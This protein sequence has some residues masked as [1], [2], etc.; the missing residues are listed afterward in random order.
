MVFQLSVVIEF[1][2]GQAQ[3]LVDDILGLFEKVWRQGDLP[4]ADQSSFLNSDEDAVRTIAN[5][6]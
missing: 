6:V 2:I 1:Q 5:A 3:K 4:I